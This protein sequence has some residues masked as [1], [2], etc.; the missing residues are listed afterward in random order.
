M[1]RTLLVAALSL[2][3]ATAFAAPVTYQL[4]SNHTNVI[5]TWS[6]F[7]FS[8]PSASFGQ[9]TGTLVY[10]AADVGKSSVEVTL[11]L[12]GLSG[13]SAKFDQHLNSP[14]FFESSKYPDAKFKS[15]KVEAAGGGKLKVTGDL[16]IKDKTAPVVLDVTLNKVGEGSDKQPRVGFD[17][18]TTVSRTAF[19]L[20]LAAPSVSDEV[21]SRITTEASV[22]KA[23]GAK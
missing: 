10:D 17:A 21:K 14:D 15:T 11:P 16:T 18:V 1:K 7:G 22:P 9:A 12:S 3:A 20:G 2:F 6:H 8:N 5:A 23:G 13:F 4:D 19:G